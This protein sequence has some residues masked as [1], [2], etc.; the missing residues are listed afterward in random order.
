MISKIHFKEIQK[1]VRS[2][3]NKITPETMVILTKSIVD[4]QI[5][6]YDCLYKIIELLFQKVRE[7]DIKM[8][9]YILYSV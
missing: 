1:K 5:T 2:I 9:K 6:T 7:N 8:Y 3:L 4:M